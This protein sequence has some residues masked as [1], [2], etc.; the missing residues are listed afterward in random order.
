MTVGEE[1]KFEQK[2]KPTAWK[3]PRQP[4]ILGEQNTYV[5]SKNMIDC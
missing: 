1:R 3:W 5:T 4:L 2:V